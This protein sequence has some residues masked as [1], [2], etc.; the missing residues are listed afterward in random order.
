MRIILIIITAISVSACAK[1]GSII[2]DPLEP[3]NRETHEV[4]KIFDQT[5]I[6]TGAKVYGDTA[7]PRFTDVIYSLADTVEQPSIIIN[8]I[9]QLKFDDALRA[10]GRFL[11]NVTLGLAGTTDVASDI[12][13]KKQKTDLGTT[14]AHWGVGEGAYVELPLFGGSPARDGVGT[15]TN[16]VYDPFNYIASP[17]VVF[18]KY[19]VRIFE[20]LANRNQYGEIID[21][22]LYESEDSYASTRIFYLQNRRFELT[23]K[24]AE[25]PILQEEPLDDEEFSDFDD[26]Y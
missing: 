25:D 7:S 8:R 14:F 3:L 19:G 5:V 26:F 16:F 13:L 18:A 11:V 22:L 1:K 20:M 6:Q 17:E 23:G 10:T 12:G 21:E 24:R 4:N 2:Y 9:L 15:V